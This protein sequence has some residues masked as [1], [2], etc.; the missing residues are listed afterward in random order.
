MLGLLSADGLLAH[1]VCGFVATQGTLPLPRALH[2][3]LGC[4]PHRGRRDETEA[5][6]GGVLLISDPWGEGERG[7]GSCTYVISFV[8]PV[9]SNKHSK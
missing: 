5:G 9:G 3:P 8:H 4:P 6:G 2:L 7:G 1:S